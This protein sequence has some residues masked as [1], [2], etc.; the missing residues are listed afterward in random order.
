MFRL[1]RTVRGLS[2][3]DVAPKIGIGHATLMRLKTVQACDADTL[4][5]LWT[6]MLAKE[7]L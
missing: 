5:K 3:C 4:L 1:Y 6:W 7:T 2:L